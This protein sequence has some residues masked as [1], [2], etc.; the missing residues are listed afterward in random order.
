[1]RQTSDQFAA[2]GAV[3]T[4]ADLARFLL[5]LS[6]GTLFD[7]GSAT[8]AEMKK[9]LPTDGANG[10]DFYGLGILR[11]DTTLVLVGVYC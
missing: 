1:V 4:A 7:N 9:W 11:Y 6:Q 8:L 3:S 5:S 10:D 2:G